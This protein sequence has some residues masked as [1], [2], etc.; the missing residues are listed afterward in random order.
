M[1]SKAELKTALS[2]LQTAVAENAANATTQ[3][4]LGIV[5]KRLSLLTTAA[6]ALG[7]AVALAPDDTQAKLELG[8]VFT[9]MGYVEEAEA[10]Y[11]ELLPHASHR[12]S[13][14]TSSLPSAHASLC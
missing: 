9:R 5:A 12:S 3:Y 8:G 11:R 2:S 10:V 4:N 13:A 1:A 6:D 14:R 7:T